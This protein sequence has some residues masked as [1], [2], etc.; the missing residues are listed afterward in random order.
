MVASQARPGY[1]FDTDLDDWVPIAGVVDTS[2]PYNFNINST[3]GGNTIIN[4]SM[5]ISG[6]RNAIIN[7]DFRINQRGF[8]SNTTNGAYTFDRWAQYNSGGTVT[9]SAQTFT[10]GSPAAPGLESPNYVRQVVSG[11]STSGQYGSLLQP[12]EDVR[13]YAGATVTISFYARA[14]SG[15]PKIAVELQQFFGSGGSPSSTVITY[16]NQVTLST[17]WARYSITTTVPSIS[18]KTIGTTANTSSLGINLWT[19]AGSDFNARSG[20]LGIQ[21]N[22]FDIWGVQVERGTIATPFEQ[23]PIGM[24]LDLCSRYYEELN[25]SFS[26]WYGV[27]VAASGD[28]GYINYPFGVQKR[29]TPI[30]AIKSGTTTSVTGWKA[31]N[32]GFFTDGTI[33]IGAPNSKL[34]N[35]GVQSNAASWGAIV[36]NG[37]DVLVSFSAEF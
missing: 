3:I 11:Q 14:G 29:I 25:L 16:A 12:I 17:S 5:P 10:A 21:N 20:S 27:N 8:T 18:G 32:G 28:R 23:R 1:I 36:M 9:T 34:Y 2:Q 15:T 24:E 13:T 35:V 22:T 31:E 30:V 19:S 4:N 7:G 6:F 37:A 26:R 33:G